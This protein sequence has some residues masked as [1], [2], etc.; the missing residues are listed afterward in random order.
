[1]FVHAQSFFAI[2]AI[3][4]LSLEDIAKEGFVSERIRRSIVSLKKDKLITQVFRGN[5]GKSGFS[6][7][8]KRPLL[9]S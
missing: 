9:I 2:K 1:M 8:R 3:E 7:F 5:L 6:L 4:N